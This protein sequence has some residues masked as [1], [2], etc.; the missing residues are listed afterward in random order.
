MYLAN[1]AREIT[2]GMTIYSSINASGIKALAAGIQQNVLEGIAFETM[3]QA[4]MFKSP[5]L[6]A[7]DGFGI[8]KNIAIG[9]L[10]QGAIGG[11][12]TGAIG[13]GVI[14]RAI[15][16]EQFYL[17]RAYGRELD[18]FI[19]GTSASNK[20]ILLQNE[21]DSMAMPLRPSGDPV[22]DAA[23]NIAASR[24][25][26][27]DK[28]RKIKNAQR[29]AINEMATSP[30]VIGNQFANALTN[31][32]TQDTLNTLLHTK[33]IGR[34]GDVTKIERAMV[35]AVKDQ[36]SMDNF[37]TRYIKLVGEDS[38]K[39]SDEYPLIHSLAD[40]AGGST[41]ADLRSSVIASAQAAGNKIDDGFTLLSPVMKK[42]KTAH[43]I[44]EKRYIWAMQLKSL[45]EETFA[46]HYTDIPVLQRALKDQR[47]AGIQ[48][49]GKDGAVLQD[50]FPSV[51][52][53]EDYI[54]ATKEDVAMQLLATTT[55]RVK[56]SGV[57][58]PHTTEGIAKIV[59]MKLGRLEGTHV[60]TNNNSDFFATQSFSEEYTAQLKAKKLL[61]AGAETVDTRFIPKYAK[62]SYDVPVGVEVAGNEVAAVAYFKAQQKLLQ[63]QV[64]N[65][66]AK[67]VGES[68]AAIIP[69]I[70][71]EDLLT[72]NTAG[73]SG[74]G[75]FSFANASVGSAG[76]K[77]QLLGT[78]TREIMLGFQKTTAETLEGAL[79]EMARKPEA[80]IEYATL[81]QKVTRS[82]K[83]WVRLEQDSELLGKNNPAGLIERNAWKALQKEPAAYDDIIDSVIPVTNKEV[84]ATI[85]AELARTSSR[86]KSFAEIN[87]VRGH[88]LEKDPDVYRPNRPDLQ[89]YTHFAFVKD[90]RVT[91]SGHTTMLHANSPEKLDAL[92]ST[93]RIKSPEF[94]VI[95]KGQSDDWFKAQGDYTYARSLNENYLNAELA[96]KG[97]FSEFYTKTDPTKIVNDILNQHLRDD[98]VLATELMRLKNES[99]FNWLEDQGKRFSDITGSTFSGSSLSRLEKEGKNPYIDYSKTALNISKVSEYP[100]IYNINTS[101]DKAV[102]TVVGK[103]RDVFSKSKSPAELDEINRI[104][105][106]SG[107]NT[108]YAN[109][110]ELLLA[111]H[112][113]PKGELTK[114]VRRANAILSTLTLGMDSMNAVVNAVSANIL[115]MTELTQM[116]R[117]AVAGDAELGGKLA[118]LY[119]TKVPGTPSDIFTPRKLIQNAFTASVKEPKNGPLMTYFRELG[120][121]RDQIEQFKLILDDFTLQGTET[122]TDFSSRMGKAFERA[123]KLQKV[124]Q[125]YS[126]NE[127]VEEMNRFV[128][129]HSM[130]Q[131]TQ[132][133]VERGILTKAEAGVYINTFVN[134]VEGNITASQRPLI[135]QGPIGQAVGLFQSYQFNLIQQMFRYVSEGSKK[136][137]AMLLGLQGTFFGL[138]SLPAF[139][140]IN[141][142]VIG[143]LSGNQNRVDAYDIALGIAGKE[144][145]EFFLYGIPSNILQANLYSRGDIN[146]RHLTIL[147]TSLADVPFVGAYSKFFGSMYESISKMAGGAPVWESMLQGLEH[148]GLSRPLSGLAQTLQATGPDGLVYSTSSKGSIL[149]SNDLFSWATAVRLAGARPMDEAVVNDSVFRVHSY[150][151]MNTAKMNKLAE[152][153]KASVIAGNQP[154]ADAIEQFAAKYVAAGGKRPQFNEWMMRQIKGATV[155]QSVQISQSLTNPFAQKVQLL[156]E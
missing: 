73:Q 101:F 30:E 122:V 3:I 11:A 129:A 41:L 83:L 40:T 107:S 127:Y 16:E 28:V 108:A 103:V 12:I 92:V 153:V 39:V 137:A 29:T 132:P 134:R 18:T 4:T 89:A 156:M 120:V 13:R 116:H 58:E 23:L 125:K 63:Q 99:A 130:Y 2:Q 80:A 111:N 36:K 19:P 74:A 38:G 21:L 94:T 14:T 8:V 76:A 72:V 22:K 48:L 50:G 144:A 140:F 53:L 150:K 109:S 85:D 148:N 24:T 114:F 131:M 37:G 81:T 117:A 77:A 6:D 126:G 65:V 95:T 123:K 68:R 147:P 124:G 54:I 152:T 90:N 33:E 42:G 121:V 55:K 113:A 67:N 106:E 79:A 110:A 100:L 139:Q 136:D 98:R 146:P 5:I 78:Q 46:I 31:T 56:R 82:G 102:S 15:K 105:A 155:P 1:S 35:Q 86:T 9:G 70:L 75:V 135:F 138:A 52:A 151:Q 154:E 43:Q 26:Y 118:Q 45:P 93:V 71:E 32:T 62:V 143:N 141:Q 27:E 96:N 87:A 51:K 17:T 112:S 25:S 20:V 104:L 97:I 142:N 115:R 34:L 47:I 10:F 145:G 128:S 91:G 44:A 60:N 69:S 7:Q 88:A 64:D 49:V 84:L 149:F 59:D 61:S 133:L 57:E 66:F 119:K